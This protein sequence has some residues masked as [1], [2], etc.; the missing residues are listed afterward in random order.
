MA[1]KLLKGL[2]ERGGLEPPVPYRV[3]G[4]AIPYPISP[5]PARTLVFCGIDARK[6]RKI[7]EQI[8][9]IDGTKV[10]TVYPTPVPGVRGRVKSQLSGG[11]PTSKID[12]KARGFVTRSL[13]AE[14]V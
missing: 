7:A 4:L 14:E 8:A 6:Y 12:P 11:F 3:H 9:D 5:E 10:G 2:A 13:A 1:Y